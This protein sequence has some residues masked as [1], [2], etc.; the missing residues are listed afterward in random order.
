[1]STDLRVGAGKLPITPPLDQSRRVGLGGLATDV[2]GSFCAR[3]IVVDDT[4]ARVALV[5]LDA[6][7]FHDNLTRGIREYVGKWTDVPPGSVLV[8]AT[9]THAAPRLIDRDGDPEAEGIC[10]ATRAYL[11]Y[12]CRQA[13]GAVFLAERRLERAGARVGETPLPGIGR[14]SRIRLR[15]GSIVSLGSTLGIDDIPPGHIESVS[16]FDDTLRLLAFETPEGRP[17]CALAAF[18][19]H[20]NL[21]LITTALNTD[22]FGWAMDCVECE[23]AGGFTMAVTPGPIGDAQPMAGLPRRQWDVEARKAIAPGRG[24]DLVPCA[25]ELLVDGIRR[26]WN[27]LVPLCGEGVH[28]ASRF[29]RFPWREEPTATGRGYI[30]GR[31]LAGGT[32]DERGAV[33]ELQLLRIGE[34]ALF[35][36]CGEVFHEVAADL[37]LHSPFAHTWP[38]SLCNDRMLYLMP[39]WEHRRELASGKGN[40]QFDQVIV[41][42]EADST[43]YRAFEAMSR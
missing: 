25:G 4:A 8:T 40:T 28:I 17:V 3:A 38:L 10:D 37:R 15:D 19:C 30:R 27:D 43:I 20:N 35:G 16:P 31:R 14:P 34:L 41:G 11:D 7:D 23:Q 33:A 18:G 39:G 5:L 9:H 36:V 29:E 21:A 2:F 24:D 12:V 42:P 6:C 1:M 26:A 13:A 32:Q 22:Y